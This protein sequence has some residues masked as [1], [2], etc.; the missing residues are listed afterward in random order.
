MY[1]QTIIPIDSNRH[2][3][4]KNRSFTLQANGNAFAILNA[5]LFRVFRRHMHMRFRRNT[6]FLRHHS[7]LRPD[8]QHPRRALNVSGKSNRNLQSQRPRIRQAQLR[9][10]FTTQRPQHRNA[11]KLAAF[12]NQF[13]PFF[14]QILSRL[15]EFFFWGQF[16][17]FAE[18]NIHRRPIQMDVPPRH[19]NRHFHSIFL[20]CA[21]ILFGNDLRHEVNNVF[22]T[23]IMHPFLLSGGWPIA[24]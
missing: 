11:G 17:A 13:H 4:Q 8:D 10:V 14:G 12:S 24:G 20:L 6:A 2:I 23:Q 21:L 5:V 19:F 9:L 18:K 3:F 7:A 1:R 22:F 16:S 15:A